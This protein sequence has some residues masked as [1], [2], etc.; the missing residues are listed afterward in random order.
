MTKNYDKIGTSVFKVC[1]FQG[2]IE[3]ILMANL[4]IDFKVFFANIYYIF[5]K[6]TIEQTLAKFKEIIKYLDF[7]DATKEFLNNIIH[8]L[9]NDRK[10]ID[11]INW[12]A[13][14]WIQSLLIWKHL[15]CWILHMVRLTPAIFISNSIED[16]P[17]LNVNETSYV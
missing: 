15:T 1:S 13:D 4:K 7:D 5:V 2:P 10:I 6:G 9:I 3:V 11:K 16:A 14:S 8:T 17:E 12:N